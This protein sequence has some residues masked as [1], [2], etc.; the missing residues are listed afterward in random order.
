M[1]SFPVSTTDFFAISQFKKFNVL[2]APSVQT[3]LD[4]YS[5]LCPIEEF[6]DRT[7][8]CVMLLTAHFLELNW[9]EDG[10]T[11]SNAVA[12]AS[13]GALSNRREI[14]SVPSTLSPSDAYLSKTNFGLSFLMLRDFIRSGGFFGSIGVGIVVPPFLA[15]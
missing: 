15:W 14:A 12:I 3:W 13:G 6:G 8:L 10:V 9:E 7:G 4:V 5:E 2:D 1:T 11:A